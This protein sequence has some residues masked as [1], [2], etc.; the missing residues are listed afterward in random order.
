MKNK[1]AKVWKDSS[2]KSIRKGIIQSLNN[3]KLEYIPLFYI[4][5]PD[6]E[7]NFEETFNTLRDIQKEGLIKYI[8]CSNFSK[9]EL[10]KVSQFC[11]IDFLQAPYNF[12]IDRPEELFLY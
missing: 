4:H 5:W 3:L 10:I 8:G 9:E 7:T 2:A 1:R 6:L 12:L 11:K